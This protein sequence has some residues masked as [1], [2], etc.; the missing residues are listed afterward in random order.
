MPETRHC[1]KCNAPL[2]EDAPEGMCPAC[3]FGA[4]L[5]LD[6]QPTP[7]L[8][9]LT[10][11]PSEGEGT[12]IGRY[13]LLQKIGEGGF[14]VV[15]MAEQE[16]P[17]RR[18]V[19]LKILKLGMDTK[20]VIARFEAERQALALMD[21]PN[22]ARILD[23]GATPGGRPYFVMDLVKGIPFNRF[24]DEQRLSVRECLELFLP[25]C[26]A[27]EHAHQKGIIHRD[28]KPSN[29]LVALYDGRPVPKVIDFGVAKATSQRLT[30]RT[31]FT[32]LHT[33]VGTLEY[34]SPEQ[35]ELN[36]FDV[37]TRSDI[38]SLGVLLYE[39]LTGTTPLTREALRQGAF[40]E[41]LRRIREEES[42][43]PSLRLSTNRERLPMISAQRKLDP[44][45]LVKAVRG[46]LDWIVMK[47]LEKERSRRYE[48]VNRFALDIQHYLNDEPVEAGP[49]T[50][51][52]RMKKFVR[53]HRAAVAVAA[54]FVVL[55]MVASVV[56]TSLALWANWERQ[57]KE[58]QRRLAEQK[59]S[60]ESKARKEAD[61]QR[62]RAVDF[63]TQI[64]MQRAESFFAADDSARGVAQLAN[65]LR[66]DPS[67]Y[68]AVE[69]LLSA[70]TF[71][72]F[73]L[74]L[75]KPLRH[76][77]E[78]YSAQ[79]S[80]D[81]RWVVTAS[82]DKT[83][84]VWDAQTGQPVSEP[85]RHEDEVWS[86]QF[87]PDGRRVVT[88]S[89]DKTARVWDAQS[90]QPIS[91]PLRHEAPVR[92]AQFSPDGRWVVTASWDNTARVWD[93]QTGQPISDPL[94]HEA[95]V[96]SAQ[97]SPDG[98]RVVTASRDK[99]ARIWD[100]QSGQPLAEP[101]RH[102]NGV[103]SAR[104]SPGGRRVVTASRDQTARVWDAESGQPASVPLWHQDEIVSAQ[105]SPDGRWVVTASWDNTARVW[106]AQTGQPL[107]LPL[108]HQDEI[109]SAQFSPDGRRVVTA[110]SDYTARVWDAQS[111]QP[112][113]IPLRHQDEVFSA[114]FSPDGRW[115][116]TA[117]RDNTARIWD[118]QSGQ[119]VSEPLRHQG[120]VWSAQ[121]S[122]DGR[123]VVTACDDKT[124][125]VWDAQSG[126]P[127]SEPLR[128]Q[129]GVWSAQFSP[130]GHRVVTASRDKTVRI[131]DAQTGQ[132]VSEPLRHGAD[133]RS[134]QF[135]PDGHRVVT[136]SYDKT[137]RVWELPY[138]LVPAPPWLP[139]LAESVAGK[140]LT[141][142][143]TVE[144]VAPEE[145]LKLKEQL[146][147]SV[148]TN[149]YARWAKWFCG[150]RS[151]RTISPLSSITVPAYV[152]RRIEEYTLESLKEAVR[153]SPTNAV[154]FARLAK[155]VLAQTE[156]DNP[157]RVEQADFYSR[158]AV[159]WAPQ[160][161]EVAK[162]RAEIAAQVQ[163]LKAP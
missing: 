23:G 160:N 37:D 130:D 22:I 5:E 104:F 119:P 17:V 11:E 110:S 58:V 137:A 69:R 97:F 87:S 30:E 6:E 59:A 66:R 45:K 139:E 115:V 99:T 113:S 90:G 57:E 154:A 79:F 91:E 8:S 44:E 145:F 67:N 14:G 4:A 32:R 51:R 148:E 68:L 25:V 92:S 122:P 63:L 105:F 93:A 28:L 162:I 129:G 150:D 78:V 155:Q 153:L 52:Y 73:D 86:A 152:Q 128:H 9:E 34:M 82:W 46:E 146:L 117:S 54:G 10:A 133:V 102:E 108:W 18:R 39:L 48:T 81:G 140:R 62:K 7:S 27:V 111:G 1:P 55:L 112:I 56:S 149:Y 71:R 60:D 83:A 33:V 141:G 161:A 64:Q 100:A 89:F 156:K 3:Q 76:E 47:A 159:K 29:V 19:A 107:S 124:A 49:P 94:R 43:K 157:R 41:V 121:F 103:L 88:A 126:Q 114:Q 136:A 132:P 158:Y 138:G 13:K 36:Q 109:F 50:L 42:P 134:A 118:A 53:K 65:V 144:P 101:L 72:N 120:G 131:W 123:R 15:Y 2:P 74:P 38:Y 163:T 35:A 98:R 85:L 95:P 26:Q 127:V 151:T 116:V 12:V 16:E 84:R 61:E 106:D 96:W 24:C 80:P 147:T 142:T 77:R 21:H 40:E 135:S 70:L 143:G 20:E 75:T 125:R 31:L